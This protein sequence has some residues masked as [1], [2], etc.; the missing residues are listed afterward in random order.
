MAPA[1]VD[2]IK[3]ALDAYRG[4]DVE[5]LVAYLHPDVEFSSAIVGPAEGQVYRGHD[6]VRRWHADSMETFAVLELELDEFEDLGERIL[7][8]GRLRARGRE[9]AVQLDSTIGWVFEVR[10][11]AVVR[12]H[13]FLDPEKAREAGRSRDP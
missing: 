2:L 9:S 6:G 1:D 13:A 10:E 4:R 7:A 11:G 5:A 12:M 8:F 3:E